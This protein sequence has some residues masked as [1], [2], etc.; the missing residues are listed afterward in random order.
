MSRNDH[1]I[2]TLIIILIVSL[3]L[4]GLV[5]IFAVRQHQVAARP[6][7]AAASRP[8]LNSEQK[9]YLSLLVVGDVRMSAAANFLGSTVTYLDGTVSNKGSKPV[10]NIELELNF[11]DS[12]NQVVLRQTVHPLADRATPLQSG[13]SHAF[14]VTFEHMPADWNQSPPLMKPVFL[15][16]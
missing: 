12:L 13:E 16:F 6:G 1:G 10:R 9:A 3:V 11:V 2:S 7:L 4:A 15:D 8:V 5:A 14:R